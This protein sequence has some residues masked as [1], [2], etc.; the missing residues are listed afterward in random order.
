[1]S[2]NPLADLRPLLSALWVFVMFNYLYADVI[3]LM[4]PALLPQFLRGEIGSVHVT[5]PFLLGAAVMMEVPIAM[6]LLA[7]VLPP[8]VNRWANV[9][10]GLFKTLAVAGSLLV[11]T[12]S[13]NYLFFACIEMATTVVIIALAWRWQTSPTARQSEN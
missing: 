12:P 8:T 7:R 9:G 1:M 5:P 6:T 10:A 2:T 4:D 13:P 3:S 11:G